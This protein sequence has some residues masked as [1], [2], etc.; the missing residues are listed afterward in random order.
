MLCKYSNLFQ[1]RDDG[2]TQTTPLPPSLFA[3]D[4]F[5]SYPFPFKALIKRMPYLDPLEPNVL[6]NGSTGGGSF[7][8]WWV[9]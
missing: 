8:V 9:W 6:H 2:H 1:T 7:V 3:I 4:K 5:S